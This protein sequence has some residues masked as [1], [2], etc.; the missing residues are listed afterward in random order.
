[1]VVLKLLMY[2]MSINP[3]HVVVLNLITTELQR[4]LQDGSLKAVDVLHVYQA[5]VNSCTE[6]N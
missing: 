2:F 1:M 5:S 4:A 3:G 6:L